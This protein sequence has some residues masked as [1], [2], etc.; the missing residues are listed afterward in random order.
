MCSGCGGR[1]TQSLCIAGEPQHG[2]WWEELFDTHP[3]IGRRIA[4]LRSAVSGQRYQGGRAGIVVPAVAGLG[5]TAF[6]CLLAIGIL[7]PGPAS[8]QAGTPAAAPATT[9]TASLPPQQPGP[10]T[11]AAAPRATAP[12]SSSPASP[13]RAGTSSARPTD[14][15]PWLPR[16][17]GGS[18]RRGARQTGLARA[19]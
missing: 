8:A 11:Q 7:N 12:A 5:T 2:R 4:R 18:Y 10:A 9:P 19:C 16:R 13:A 17:W 1:L 6:A 3:S 14:G 15:G